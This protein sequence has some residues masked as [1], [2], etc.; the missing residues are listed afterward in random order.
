M[1]Q[2]QEDRLKEKLKE[3]LSDYCNEHDKRIYEGE[4]AD[5]LIGCLKAVDPLLSSVRW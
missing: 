2:E 5:Y 3:A 1:T 4:M